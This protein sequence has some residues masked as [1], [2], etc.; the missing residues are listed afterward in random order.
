M[1]IRVLIADDDDMMRELLSDIVRKEGYIPIEA[2]DGKEALE[3]FFDQ[4][5]MDLMILDIMMPK[6]T[7]WEVLKEIREHSDVPVL[8]LTALGDELTEVQGLREGADDYIAKPFSYAVLR[9][10]INTLL[11]KVVKERT[12]TISEGVIT[13]HQGN[14]QVEVNGE[15]VVLNR[16]EYSLLCY[17]MRNRNQVL[18]REQILGSLWGY[19]FQGDIRTIDTH[20]KMLRSK[21]MAGGAY[22]RTVRGTGYMFEV[23]T[24]ENH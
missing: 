13:V 21:L 18:T 9:A 5:T 1:D 12:S 2:R 4:K 16:K 11:R 7:G 15:P 19:D 3:M 6:Y 24:H 23:T 17:F 8:M 10:R 20:I 22:I 14:Q